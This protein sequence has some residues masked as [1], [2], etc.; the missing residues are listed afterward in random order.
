MVRQWGSI[1]PAGFSVWRGEGCWVGLVPPQLKTLSWKVWKVKSVPAV[2]MC[3]IL[4]VPPFPPCK[5]LPKCLHPWTDSSQ[6]SPLSQETRAELDLWACS[7]KRHTPA[8]QDAFQ[9]QTTL[10]FLTWMLHSW[11]VKPILASNSFLKVE[12]VFQKVRLSKYLEKI[13]GS[14]NI[15]LKVFM[16]RNQRFSHWIQ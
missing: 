6:K 16:H 4:H 10:F 2:F 12:T 13:R 3:D 15:T 9:N 11:L 8:L 1:C 14:K 7:S 5:A